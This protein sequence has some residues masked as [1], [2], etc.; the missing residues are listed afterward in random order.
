[1]CSSSELN[2]GVRWISHRWGYLPV[3]SHAAETQG[4]GDLSPV[5]ATGRG[6][7]TKTP[8][9]LRSLKQVC[10][11]LSSLCCME[12]FYSSA[13]HLPHARCDPSLS[14][15]FIGCGKGL[16]IHFLNSKI[17]AIFKVLK[18]CVLFLIF[19]TTHLV[20]AIFCPT[21]ESCY[22]KCCPFVPISSE[23]RIWKSQKR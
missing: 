10:A 3:F 4:F 11:A 1:M 19:P 12:R 20:C 7:K 18:A 6:V 2:N 21:L 9:A 17:A 13:S 15:S 23:N 14:S 8:S 16:G 22:S 5:A